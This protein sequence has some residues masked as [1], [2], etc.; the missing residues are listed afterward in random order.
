MDGHGSTQ[1]KCMI[2]GCSACN[3]GGSCT[4]CDTANGWQTYVEGSRTICFWVPGMCG[5]NCQTCVTTGF[6][7]ST[8]NTCSACQAR[9]YLDTYNSPVICKP[10]LSLC[11]LCTSLYGCITCDTNVQK[12]TNSASQSFCSTSQCQSSC[13]TCVRT[14]FGTA[15]CTNCTTGYFPAVKTLSLGSGLYD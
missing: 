4:T 7:T 5:P 3:T 10:C 2:A 13:T 11:S 8:S 9:H 12:Y 14:N 15:N 6:P 1:Y